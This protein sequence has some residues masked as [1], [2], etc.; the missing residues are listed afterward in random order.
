MTTKNEDLLNETAEILLNRI[1]QQA[2]ETKTPDQTK[3]LAEAFAIIA[4]HDRPV[5]GE[6]RGRGAI[7]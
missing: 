5:R 2:P 4:Q 7:T 1:K 3:A 6:G